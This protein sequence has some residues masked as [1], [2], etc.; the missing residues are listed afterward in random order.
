MCWWN[1]DALVP[2]KTNTDI[3]LYKGHS[4]GHEV[5]FAVIWKGFIGWVWIPSMKFQSPDKQNLNAPEFHYE[6]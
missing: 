3:F 4:Q 1:M 2:T 5:N 6:S